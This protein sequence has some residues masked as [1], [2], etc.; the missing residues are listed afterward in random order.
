MTCKHFGGPRNAT[1]KKNTKKVAD[2]KAVKKYHKD[3]QKLACKCFIKFKRSATSSNICVVD[4]QCQYTHPIP[5][6]ST[7]YAVYRKQ[8]EGTKVLIIKILSLSSSNAAEVVK[9]I[10]YIR[11]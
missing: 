7:A 1:V 2:E 8:D 5:K 6:Y 9:T 3:T 4:A 10:R 11:L